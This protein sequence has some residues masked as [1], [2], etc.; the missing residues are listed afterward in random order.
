MASTL[1]MY[2][3]RAQGESFDPVL[4]PFLAVYGSFVGHFTIYFAPGESLLG[5]YAS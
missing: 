2:L 1:E 3:I 4:T 5:I